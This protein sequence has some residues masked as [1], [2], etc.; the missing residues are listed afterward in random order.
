MTEHRVVD[1][2]G[3]IV[4]DLGRSDWADWSRAGELLF[5]R[6]VGLFRVHIDKRDRPDCPEQLI[7]LGSLKFEPAAAPS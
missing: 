5:S 4:I 2:R 6:Q 1:D 7:D 3:A